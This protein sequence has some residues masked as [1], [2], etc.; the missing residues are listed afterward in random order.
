MVSRVSIFL[1][2]RKFLKYLFFGILLIT[3][4]SIYS[5]TSYYVSKSGNDS[6]T[7]NFGAPFLTISQAVSVINPGDQIYIREGVYHENIVFN[8][9]DA[10]MVTRL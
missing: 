4:L 6:N 1:C 8:N 7:G 10:Q 3:S 9:I 5:Q 2:H